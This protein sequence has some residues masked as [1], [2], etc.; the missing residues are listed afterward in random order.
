MTLCCTQLAAEVA[1]FSTDDN[2][3]NVPLLVINGSVYYQDVTINLNS[4][5]GEFSILS[6]SKTDAASVG[7]QSVTL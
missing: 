1:T 6:A 4:K 2:T 3:L 5:T 7:A